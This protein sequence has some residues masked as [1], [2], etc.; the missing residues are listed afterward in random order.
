MQAPPEQIPQAY[1]PPTEQAPLVHAPVTKAPPILAPPAQEAF[2]AQVPSLQAP[3]AQAEA[4]LIQAPPAKILPVPAPSAPAPV[5]QAPPAEKPFPA[6]APPVQPLPIQVP[7]ASAP[8]VQATLVEFSPVQERSASASSAPNEPRCKQPKNRPERV[9]IGSPSD[10]GSLVDK[11][12]KFINKNADVPPPQYTSFRPKEISR[13]IKTKLPKIRRVSQGIVHSYFEIASDNTQD[14]YIRP[15]REPISQLGVSSHSIVK[16]INSL[17]D[18][19]EAITTWFAIYHPQYK[20]KLG[21]TES[22]HDPF[23][24]RLLPKPISLLGVSSD[25]AVKAFAIYHPHYKEKLGMTESVHDSFLLRLSPK[26]EKQ[27]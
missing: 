7:P 11:F 21:I 2:S 27:I 24:L 4:S 10:V 20:E 17:P 13:S 22:A 25:C 14:F 26:S 9:N 5:T 6:Q 15:P 8:L 16:V 3:P 19:P 18:L 23:L 1:V 12:F